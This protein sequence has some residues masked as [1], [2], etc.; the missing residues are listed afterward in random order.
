VNF[1]KS[2]PIHLFTDNAFYISKCDNSKREPGKDSC[3]D[4]A[5]IPCTYE[6]FMAGNGSIR[7]VIS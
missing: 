6:E 7:W 4:W 2:S 1:L 3:G 5:N